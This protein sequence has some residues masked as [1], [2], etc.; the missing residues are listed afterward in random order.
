[1]PNDRARYAS[2]GGK[3]NP[4]QPELIRAAVARMPSSS[5]IV[6][7]MDADSEGTKL[8]EIVR[9][10]VELSGRSD[11]RFKLQE[12]FGHKDWMISRE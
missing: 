3:L 6:A 2:I 1:M 12:P 7:A 9:R 4:Q 10:A 5:E 11:L 8:A